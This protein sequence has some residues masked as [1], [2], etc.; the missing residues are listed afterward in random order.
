LSEMGTTPKT[1]TATITATAANGESLTFAATRAARD[2]G[3]CAPE[4]YV[5]WDGPKDKGLQAAKLGKAPFTFD[6]VVVLDGR[7]HVAHA[8][9]PDDTIKGN[10]PS[11]RLDFTPPLPAIR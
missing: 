7:K 8:T 11:V 2:E 6:V 10:E 4:G 3:T 1:A 5:Y 9:W